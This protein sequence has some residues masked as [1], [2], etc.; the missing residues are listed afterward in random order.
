M[1]ELKY[2][3][4]RH[5][6][7]RLQQH[8]HPYCPPCNLYLAYRAMPFVLGLLLTGRVVA[9]HAPSHAASEAGE[10]VPMQSAIGYDDRDAL[11]WE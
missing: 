3:N 5:C 7:E 10:G 8:D 11:I 2:L 9:G 6:G 4:C 1:A